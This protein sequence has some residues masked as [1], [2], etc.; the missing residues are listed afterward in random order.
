MEINE[1]IGFRK[2]NNYIDN[3][4]LLNERESNR[5]QKVEDIKKD[6]L[7]ISREGEIA[8]ND[9]K[10]LLRK[11]EEKNTLIEMVKEN[12]EN[13]D[14]ENEIDIKIKCFKIYL[15]MIKGDKVPLKDKNYLMKHEPKLYTNALLFKKE[16]D[17][18]KK[19]ESL[20]KDEENRDDRFNCLERVAVE[21]RTQI[22]SKIENSLEE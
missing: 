13:Q 3:R 14:K 1:L 18:P 15:R 20:V 6:I 19:H 10:N 7:K 16:K 5:N 8:S 21:D 9:F 12:R 22:L 11:K 4:E 17:K 2:T